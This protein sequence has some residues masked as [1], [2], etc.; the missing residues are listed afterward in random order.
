MGLSG[1]EE[2]INDSCEL[3]GS[4]VM[5]NLKARIISQRDSENPHR[6]LYL[7]S[8]GEGR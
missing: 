8:K 1:R 6:T 2:M 5:L 4:A 7:Y 3:V